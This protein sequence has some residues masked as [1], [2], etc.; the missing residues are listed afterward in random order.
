MLIE[1]PLLERED[2]LAR[3]AALVDAAVAGHGGVA[4]VEGEAGIGK[5]RL[6][7]AARA[8]ATDAGATVLLARGGELERRFAYG[9]VRQL[10]ERV[11]RARDA[12][13]REEL[14]AGAAAPAAG[15]LGLSDVEPIATGPDAPFVIQHAFYWLTANLVSERPLLICV[16]DAHWADE[17][18]WQWLVHLGRRIEDLPVALMI[19][20]RVG[21]P[22]APE[23]Q[24]AALREEADAE[25]VSPAALSPDAAGTLVRSSLGDAT[26][27]ALLQACWD[28]TGGNPFFLWELVQALSREALQPDA[29]A[30][31]G[32]STLTPEAV[33]QSVVARLARQPPE[34][35]ALA[36]AAAVLENEAESRLVRELAQVPENLARQ[37]LAQLE[38]TRIATTQGAIRFVHPILRTAVYDDIAPPLRAGLHR[39]TADLLA[40]EGRLDVAAVHLL[41]TDPAA[42]AVVVE[43]LRE[44]AHRA[45]AQGAPGAAVTLL[46]RARDEPPRDADRPALALELGL[47]E[48]LAGL[49]SAADSLRAALA[50]A[51]DNASRETAARALASVLNYL[52]RVDEA[53][54]VLEGLIDEI[55]ES[56]REQRLGL[57]VE[58]VV[59]GSSSMQH[60][61]RLTRR[62][63]ELVLG[64]KGETPAE[65]ALLGVYAFNHAM[66]RALPRA[67][68]VDAAERAWG[69]G[70]LLADYGPERGDVH[71]LAVAL[72]VVDELDHAQ[73]VADA[74]VGAAHKRGALAGRAMAEANRGRLHW[75]RGN[76]AA[77]EADLRSALRVSEAVGTGMERMYVL[78]LLGTVLALRGELDEA[79]RLLADH[80]V[81]DADPPLNIQS[82]S[83]LDARAKLHLAA[84]RPAEAARDQGKVAA[85]FAERG[86][87]LSATWVRV[88]VHAL[89][90]TGCDEEARR[91]AEQGVAA[92]RRSE[93]VGEEGLALAALA[94]VEGGTAGV[95]M[96]V[97]AAELMERC[98][99]PLDRA[100]VLLDLGS[101]LR[102]ANRRADARDPLQLALDLAHPRGARLITD[103]AEREL[104]ATGARP[105]SVVFSGV[106]SLTPSER[107]VAELVAAGHTNRTI[108]QTLFVTPKTVET[109]LRAVFRK[110][111]ITAR[112]EVSARL[113]AEVADAD[114]ELRLATIVAVA[115][116]L[117]SAQAILAEQ[118][119]RHRGREV[120]RWPE[121]VVV[122]FGAA[123]PALQYARD[124]RDGLAALG[125]DC[126]IGVDAGECRFSDDGVHGVP[127]E[128]ARQ[129]AA[130]AE[131][132]QV[133]VSSAVREIADAAG[134]RAG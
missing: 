29:D 55:P 52:A 48:Q 28:A 122:A 78:F 103:A 37:A 134:L 71:Y 111:D 34:V 51:Q 88:L 107:R 70:R 100:E 47:A 46:R 50:C 36:R 44:A 76:L 85:A 14:L 38:E 113:G 62:L 19:A 109:H 58:L 75:H 16:D 79:R 6:L 123:T 95:D 92:A 73:D 124:L 57:E 102:R 32:V 3:L 26:H 12:A 115:G 7:E 84:G 40:A 11:V 97:Q 45:V 23:Q 43:L 31:A 106:D 114:G 91:A 108:A 98:P 49:P 69:N 5:S 21:E 89:L 130:T 41:R 10:F 129:L 81:W 116:D 118:L 110:L 9:V 74:T 54:E 8:H 4:I 87:A 24:R 117:A 131:P 132:R 125:H 53:V 67:E 20:W 126:G 42:D 68:I 15:V 33:S 105:R 22:G 25:T 65:R 90:A 99:R 27:P 35:V 112:T 1:G 93:V 80:G 96:L 39:Q 59:T 121:A 83:V 120:S 18:S 2:E 61:A 86:L 60:G 104:R 63:A 94:A 82:I 17:D 128:H 77:A 119:A 72:M 56:Q 101:A 64:I 13:D 133:I 30:A 66:A 127:V